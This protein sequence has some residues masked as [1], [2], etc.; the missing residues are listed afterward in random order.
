MKKKI[1]NSPVFYAYILIYFILISYNLK[2]WL[3][4]LFVAILVSI[5]NTK[6]IL[7]LIDYVYSQSKLFTKLLLTIL[8]LVITFGFIVLVLFLLDRINF[9]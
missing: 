5:V 9:L 1:L 8:L 3:L 4:N 2:N 7:I 6:I